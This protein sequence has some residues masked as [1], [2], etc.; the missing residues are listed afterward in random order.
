[1]QAWRYSTFG[2]RLRDE[3]FLALS[4]D[5]QWAEWQRIKQ[6]L[7]AGDRG[8]QQAL[9]RMKCVT[10]SAVGQWRAALQVKDVI[11]R[12]GVNST[13]ET[14]QPTHATAIGRAFRKRYGKDWPEGAAQNRGRLGEPRFPP[15]G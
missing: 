2:E 14:F 5:E 1:V 7:A 15:A 6:Q 11:D 4:E 12:S 9:A 8:D 3:T 13:F 10:P